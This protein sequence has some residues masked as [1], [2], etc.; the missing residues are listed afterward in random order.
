LIE[1]SYTLGNLLTCLKFLSLFSAITKTRQPKFK[2]QQHLQKCGFPPLH[3]Q[4][5]LILHWSL[6]WMVTVWNLS[7]T[8]FIIEE[9]KLQNSVES[10][11]IFKAFRP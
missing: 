11:S 2:H 1:Y 3:I 6:M 9:I 10:K 7:T 5:K 4:E 8:F